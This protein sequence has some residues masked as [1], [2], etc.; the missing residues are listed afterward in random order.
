MARSRKA[1]KGFAENPLA[2]IASLF[3]IMEA[4]FVYPVTKLSGSNQTLFVHFMV[5]FPILVV[6]GFFLI[7]WFKPGHLYAPGEY[8]S[9]NDYL[10]SIGKVSAIPA[11]ERAGLPDSKRAQPPVDRSAE[12]KR[13]V[14]QPTLAEEP[15]FKT[16]MQERGADVADDP[17]ELGREP[18]RR[19]T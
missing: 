16:S 1:R 17:R 18:L 19:G 6:V 13:A 5:G 7:L 10:R 11:Q 2:V 3:S 8:E 9:S 15:P 14:K 12:G 4:A